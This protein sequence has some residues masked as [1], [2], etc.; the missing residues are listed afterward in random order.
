MLSLFSQIFKYGSTAPSMAPRTSINKW[1]HHQLFK[2]VC[3]NP[4][5]KKVHNIKVVDQIR[6]LRNLEQK[7]LNYCASCSCLT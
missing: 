7:L 5:M 3:M 6:Q 2:L 1:L 4:N